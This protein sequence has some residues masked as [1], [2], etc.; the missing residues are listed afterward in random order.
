MPMIS[1]L[2]VVPTTTPA[3]L[4]PL[5]Q[6]GTTAA[7]TVG[8]VLGSTQPAIIL[9]SGDLLGRVSLGPG[10]PESIAVGT[11]I[12]ISAGTL[13]ALG[14]SGAPAASSVTTATLVGISQNGTDQAVPYATFLDGITID[15]AQ[16]AGPAADSDTTWVAQG[17]STMLRQTFAAVWAWIETKIPTYKPPVVE[18]TVSTTLDG[19]VHNG[20]LLVCS[21]PLSLSTVF[22][23]MG[24]GFYCQ[25][26]NLSGGSVGLGAGIVTSNGATALAPGQYATLQGLTYSG[27]SVVF[28]AVASSA[29]SAPG[30][31]SGLTASAA[32]SSSIS[33]AWIA[34][35]AGG[36]V[37]TYTV[38]YRV[39][40]TTAWNTAS[41]AVTTTTFV[42][43]G[44]TAATSY[45]FMV[46]AVNS[47]GNG[48]NSAV[49]TL[50]TLAASGTVTAIAWN[51]T[52]SGSYVHGSGTIGVN[53]QITPSSAPVQFGFST[54]A[55]TQPAA[56]TAGVFVSGSLWGAYVPIP[57]TAGT[58]YAW[59][60]GTDGSTPTV[61]ATAFTVT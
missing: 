40:G 46:Y 9:P 12:T 4:I 18:L 56:W 41:S 58:Y 17:G 1:Q 32:T 13:S 48:A 38:Q 39:T 3:D 49:T 30:A 2:P 44:L 57:A 28:A 42:V 55:T 10:G 29:T 34:P 24:S 14:I 53:A 25:V 60:E 6:A 15:L 54:S 33:L 5:S 22:T 26:L 11:G 43:T 27:G 36:G 20:R 23:N 31:V 21:Q 37:L 45:D 19:T 50:S 51:L 8:T 61:Y 16:P 7:V 59:C 47:F 52:P 35:S